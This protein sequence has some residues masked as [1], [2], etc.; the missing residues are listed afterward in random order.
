MRT[1]AWFYRIAEMCIDDGRQW[2]YE[3][4]SARNFPEA[5]LI[6]FCWRSYKETNACWSK[7]FKNLGLILYADNFFE[8]LVSLVYNSLKL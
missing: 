1:E 8:S 7:E 2:L 6:K 3:G 5:D 4:H